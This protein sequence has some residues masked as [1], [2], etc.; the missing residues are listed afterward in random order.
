MCFTY[1]RDFEKIT[2]L[3][4][5][6]FGD[7]QGHLVLPALRS[8]SGGAGWS[9]WCGVPEA[10]A[11]GALSPEW[12]IRWRWGRRLLELLLQSALARG[13]PRRPGRGR[14]RGQVACR[15]LGLGALGVGDGVGAWVPAAG[16]RVGGSQ[17][18]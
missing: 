11:R 15:G 8:R 9:H 16:L 3:H 12:F 5:H 2:V 14:P 18:P 7:L 4:G 6:I 10:G 1:I 13:R 17:V